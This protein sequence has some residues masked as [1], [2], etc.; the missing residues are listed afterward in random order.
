MVQQ[1]FTHEE[2]ARTQYFCSSGRRRELPPTSELIFSTTQLYFS[3]QNYL[4]ES[5]F[6]DP[7]VKDTFRQNV[8]PALLT[9]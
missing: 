5:A 1:Y 3:W 2:M 4:M 8:V 7:K 9:L 6:R